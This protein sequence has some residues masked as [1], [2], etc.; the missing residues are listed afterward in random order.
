MKKNLALTMAMIAAMGFGLSA[1]DD[2]AETATDATEVSSEAPAAAEGTVVETTTSVE[3]TT[4]TV[5]TPADP[6]ADGASVDVKIDE[7]GVPAVTVD[8]NTTTTT[9]TTTIDAPAAMDAPKEEIH[10]DAE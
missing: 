8:T 5:E 3:G 6:V 1:C 9:T 7:A 10:Q 2:K 4:V